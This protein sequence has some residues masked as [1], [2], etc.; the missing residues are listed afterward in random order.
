VFD[1]IENPKQKERS[2]C[3]DEKGPITF[4]NLDAANDFKLLSK[5]IAPFTCKKKSTSLQ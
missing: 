2:I 4:I 5:D 3:V 1:G